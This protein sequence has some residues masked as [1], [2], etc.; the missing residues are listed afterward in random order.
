[1]W[2]RVTNYARVDD[3]VFG[4]HS[5]ELDDFVFLREEECTFFETNLSILFDIVN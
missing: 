2:G 4:E 5:G 3:L 1:M